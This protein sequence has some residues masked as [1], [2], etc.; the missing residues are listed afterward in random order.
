MS[1]HRFNGSD[2]FRSKEEDR[3]IH[4][5]LADQGVKLYL[6]QPGAIDLGDEVMPL[7][8]YILEDGKAVAFDKVR[9]L[10]QFV[11]ALNSLGFIQYL[12]VPLSSLH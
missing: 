6:G 1:S 4:K 3:L 5:R 11:V 2:H 8:Q 10:D 9:S 12:G 7:P